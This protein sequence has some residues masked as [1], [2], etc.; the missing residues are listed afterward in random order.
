[1]IKKYLFYLIRWQLSTPILAVVLIWLS[2]LSTLTATIIAN[3]IGGL[4]F[5]WVDKFIF[6]SISKKPMW[7]IE[8]DAV[9]VD[10]GSQGR[11]YRIVEWLGYNRK[12]DKHP[13]Y[14]CENCRDAKMREVGSRIKKT[15]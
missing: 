2:D 11:G 8:D 4:I 9:C 12:Q 3:L 14:R 1:M 10:C 7:E 5:F 13:Q 6:K 15:K